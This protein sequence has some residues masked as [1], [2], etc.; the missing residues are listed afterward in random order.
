MF[1]ALI[2]AVLIAA[3]MVAAGMSLFLRRHGESNQPE[4]GWVWTDE[5]FRDPV[6]NR[7]MRVWSDDGGG[8]YCV[9]ESSDPHRPGAAS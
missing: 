5:V 3:V 8:R 9:P 4:R 6:T 7:V 1:F 2:G